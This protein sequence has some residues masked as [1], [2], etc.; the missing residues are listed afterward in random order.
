[1]DTKLSRQ[2][3][4]RLE[5]RLKLYG[6]YKPYVTMDAG[7]MYVESYPLT[8]SVR[9][10]FDEEKGPLHTVKVT[11]CTLPRLGRDATLTTSRVFMGQ[12]ILNHVAH[13]LMDFHGPAHERSVQQDRDAVHIAHAVAQTESSL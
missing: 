9:S 7:T 4:V 5:R 8:A 2:E 11:D 13:Q 1:M 6:V 10:G 12:D 3:A